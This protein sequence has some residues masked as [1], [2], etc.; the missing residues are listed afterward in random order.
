MTN[1]HPIPASL[2]IGNLRAVHSILCDVMHDAPAELRRHVT[3]GAGRLSYDQFRLALVHL[4]LPLSIV[5]E[6]DVPILVLNVATP[7]DP[8]PLAYIYPDDIGADPE[9]LLAEQRARMADA[10]ED[11]TGAPW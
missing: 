10:L 4:W 3:R 11:I 8:M 2:T 5:I 1:W 6:D 7:E 9:Y